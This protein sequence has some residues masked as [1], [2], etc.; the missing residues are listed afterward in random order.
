MQADR[1]FTNLLKKKK[2]PLM[3]LPFV[4]DFLCFFRRTS[5]CRRQC[6][7]EYTS[8]LLTARKIL[9]Y[10]QGIV[11]EK[12]FLEWCKIKTHTHTEEK[13]IK[14][15]QLGKK[16]SQ[17]PTLQ[18]MSILENQLEATLTKGSHPLSIR[19]KSVYDIFSLRSLHSFTSRCVDISSPTW[20]SKTHPHTKKK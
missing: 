3:S 7:R 15:T 11:K 4:F 1:K 12:I 19:C 14:K 2:S 20:T 17:W 18:W 13:I 16:I 9:Y 5:C 6:K 8:Y 10:L